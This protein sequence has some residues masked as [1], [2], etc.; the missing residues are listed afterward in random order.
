MKFN[1]L[2]YISRISIPMIKLMKENPSVISM[3]T[4]MID[5]KVK[6]EIV[7]CK[8]VKS[9]YKFR[10]AL[11]SFSVE[12]DRGFIQEFVLHNMP[13]EHNILDDVTEFVEK[14]AICKAFN[15]D[16]IV[17]FV[18]N[19]PKYLS[20]SNRVAEFSRQRKRED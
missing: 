15:I 18:S 11:K 3:S 12:V 10:S 9:S 6:C 5:E 20:Y 17:D 2:M 1:K 7:V 13:P 4:S 16:E 19:H 14:A 8:Q